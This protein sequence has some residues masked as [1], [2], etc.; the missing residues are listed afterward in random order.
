MEIWG[1]KLT[2]RE[3]PGTAFDEGEALEFRQQD[4]VGTMAAFLAQ[5]LSPWPPPWMFRPHPRFGRPF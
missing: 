1:L 3:S 2:V 4:N 5:A